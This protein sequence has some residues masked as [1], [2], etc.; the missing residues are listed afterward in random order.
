MFL[1]SQFSLSKFAKKNEGKENIWFWKDMQW[2]LYSQ[3]NFR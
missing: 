3:L 2:T 1:I